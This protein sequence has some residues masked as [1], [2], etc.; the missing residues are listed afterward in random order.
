V[1]GQDGI[2]L[3][4]T[5]D[6]QVV[7]AFDAPIDRDPCDAKVQQRFVVALLVSPEGVAMQ[8]AGRT[9]TLK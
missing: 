7:I 8:V 9:L 1:G 5:E 3:T 6:A 4:G 2:L